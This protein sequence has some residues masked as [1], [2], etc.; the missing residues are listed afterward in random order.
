MWRS[1]ALDRLF[2]YCPTQKSNGTNWPESPFLARMGLGLAS[3]SVT[4]SRTL[5]KAPE[6]R[7]IS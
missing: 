5:P 3:K 1:P 2:L 4:P 6:D 7:S